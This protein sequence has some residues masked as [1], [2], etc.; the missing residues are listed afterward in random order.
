MADENGAWKEGAVEVPTFLTQKIAC[1]QLC[2][3]LKMAVLRRI[4][5]L[6]CVVL[7]G[8]STELFCLKIASN[9]AILQEYGLVIAM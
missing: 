5:E 8:E 4:S 9:R 3:H 2:G 7:T 1:S 6:N